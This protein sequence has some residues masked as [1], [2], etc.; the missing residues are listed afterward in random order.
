MSGNQVPRIAEGSTMKKSNR[1]AKALEASRKGTKVQN[2]VW[3][4]SEDREVAHLLRQSWELMEKCKRKRAEIDA[5]VE[6][7]NSLRNEIKKA[8]DYQEVNALMRLSTELSRL[9]SIRSSFS[10]PGAKAKFGDA[11][12]LND[13]LVAAIDAMKRGDRISLYELMGQALRE[14][15]EKT[16]EGLRYDYQYLKSIM[17][18]SRP[19]AKAKFAHPLPASLESALK[20]LDVKLRMLRHAYESNDIEAMS[21]AGDRVLE[22]AERVASTSD[23]AAASL[24][25]VGHHSRPGAKANGLTLAQRIA[26][27]HDAKRMALR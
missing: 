26:V 24:S 19:G 3:T 25:R 10:R 4:S 21:G 11:K 12:K 7:I 8:D 18:L 20:N 15:D 14:I 23:S 17:H 16:P 5:A 13:L 27:A 6:K 1:Y 9:D 2:S 22:A